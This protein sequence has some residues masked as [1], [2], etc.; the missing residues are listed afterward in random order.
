VLTLPGYGEPVAGMPGD[1][2]YAA[3][4]NP[5]LAAG[6]DQPG[7]GSTCHSGRRVGSVAVEP[8]SVD[9]GGSDVP[10][11]AGDRDIPGTA[12]DTAGSG[13]SCACAPLAIAVTAKQPASHTGSQRARLLH[14]LAG[15]WLCIV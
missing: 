4:C 9:P 14:G 13:A 8:V 5:S 11:T 10:G 12:G 6:V 15:M 2:W 1:A 3:G 7:G